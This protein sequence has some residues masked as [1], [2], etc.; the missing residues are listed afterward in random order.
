MTA[1]SET[2]DKVRGFQ[3]GAVDCITKPVQYE[4]VLARVTA[5]LML[6]NLTKRLLE[7]NFCLRREICDR[8]QA[9]EQLRELE[10]AYRSSGGGKTQ[11]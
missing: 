2:V 11:V 4:E 3:L 9:E 10:A 8:K 6:R 5:H 1:L 7:Q